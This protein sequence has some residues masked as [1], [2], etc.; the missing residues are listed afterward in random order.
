MLH[1]KSQTLSWYS[2]SPYIRPVKLMSTPSKV[3]AINCKEF[4]KGKVEKGGLNKAVPERE[5]LDFYAMNHLM[6]VV[7]AEFTP[8]EPLPEWAAKV[9]QIYH[10]VL[11][12][13][14]TRML[15]YMI[16]ITVRESR[17]IHD[18]ST[19]AF[20]AK[21]KELYGMETFDFNREIRG[22]GSDAAANAF[23]ES[24]MET[25]IGVLSSGITYMFNNGKFGGGYGGKPWGLI[26]QTLEH[27]L[28]GKTSMEVMLDTSYTLAHNN[29]PMFNKGMLYEHFGQGLYTILDVQRSGQIPEMILNSECPVACSQDVFYCLDVVNKLKPHLFG[30][31][32]NW[33][34]VKDLGALH[35]YDSKI[36]E[37]Q[38]KFPPK[39]PEPEKTKSGFLV[40]GAFPV[41]P[42]K[43]AKIF[44]R[45]KKLETNGV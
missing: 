3:L 13:Q 35:N 41:M 39:P 1:G 12:R 27:M 2:E 33:Q 7:K 25:S 6:A 30:S 24:N 9:A 45:K 40:T 14:G 28:H 11:E 21:Y 32:V 20:W 18:H 19:D 29:G 43:Q 36:K 10:Q 42:G 23:V 17:H 38:S 26:S 37:Q 16:L 34:Q 4:W 5:A 8:N 15:F 22:K 31:E 44:I